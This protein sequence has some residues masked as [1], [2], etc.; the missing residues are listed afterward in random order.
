M[1]KMYSKKQ[2]EEI[3]KSSG[4]KLYRHF[5]ETTSGTDSIIIISTNSSP[6]ADINNLSKIITDNDIFSIIVYNDALSR[7]FYCSVINITRGE[8]VEYP[9]MSASET[10][11][12]Q[13]D[14]FLG[15][16]DNVTPL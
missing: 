13:F 9:D 8:L 11:K 12:L 4:T 1:R 2:I 3:A 5:I 14:S 6:Y 15:A 10:P 7:F 16:I